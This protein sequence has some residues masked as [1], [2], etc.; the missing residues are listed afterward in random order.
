MEDLWETDP[1]FI[2]ELADAV[3]T[4]AIDHNSTSQR[5]ANRTLICIL[6][7]KAFAS[8]PISELKSRA[9]S[10]WDR[11]TVL[12]KKALKQAVRIPSHALR[13]RTLLNLAGVQET[14]Q[15]ILETHDVTH[16]VSWATGI[17]FD[18]DATAGLQA[19]MRWSQASGPGAT[20]RMS[21]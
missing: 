6:A 1:V 14:A 11:L 4:L 19:T 8:C 3:K 15:P 7:C 17:R 2:Y 12:E 13:T 21:L 10:A 16:H 5:Q 18:P 9:W 20:T